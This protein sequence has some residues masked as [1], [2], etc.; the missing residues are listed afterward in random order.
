MLSSKDNMTSTSKHCFGHF[1]M[2]NRDWRQPI[3]GS[4]I[5]L[6]EILFRKQLQNFY[7]LNLL[8]PVIAT[9]SILSFE[10]F[11]F[12]RTIRDVFVEISYLLQ[13]IFHAKKSELWEDQKW[14]LN[15]NL[16]FDKEWW[17]PVAQI[18]L[19]QNNASVLDSLNFI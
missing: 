3:K 13:S 5:F 17:I 9:S 19:F 14:Y 10:V 18:H 15:R 6:D 1:C 8:F 11:A 7:I 4:D 2:K 12:I 16:W